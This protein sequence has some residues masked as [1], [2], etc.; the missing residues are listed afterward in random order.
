MDHHTYTTLVSA[1]EVD[2]TVNP[3]TFRSKVILISS[4]AYVVL[5]GMLIAMALLIYFGIQH[6]HSAHRTTTLIRIGLF[7]LVM[8]PAFFVVLRM[9]FMRLPAPQGRALTRDEAPRLFGVLDKMRR[10][11]QGPPIHHVLIDE[12]F[13]A[14]ISQRPRWG[15]FGG[16][17]NYLMLGLPYMLSMSPKEMLAT[18]AHEYGH[19]CGNHGK[20]SAWVYRQR[21]TFGAL[22]EQISDS[23]EDNWVH[24]GMARMLDKFMPYYNAHTFVLSRQDEYDADRTATDLVGARANASGLIRGELLGRWIHQEFWPTLFRQANAAAKPA[25]MPFSAMRTAFKASYP[26]W[27]T[28]ENLALAW[29]AK[30]DLH[31]THP[32]LRDRVEATGE[33]ATLPACIEVCAAE[34]LLGGRTRTLID[35]FD[36]DWWEK[37]KKGWQARYQHVTR[38]TT[39][40]QQLRRMPQSEMK[41]ADLQ[42]YAMLSAEFEPPEAAK[43]VLEHLL[44]Q[45]GGPFPRAELEYGRLLLAEQNDL[46]LTHLA[47][48]VKA[49]RQLGEQAARTG[50]AYLL[51]HQGEQQAQQWWDGV[52]P[53][54]DD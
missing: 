9:F 40:L 30:S 23:S 37:E 6:A 11:L 31:D 20:L 45:P 16:H 13:N 29:S 7:T 12:Q 5:F 49:D 4:A 27:A 1:L 10:Q 51:R 28:K 25:F 47:T 26:Q 2:A 18:V 24:G 46:G 8:V 50:Y 22:Y 43:T 32:A 17:T 15:L 44:R 38:S 35:E 33:D 41:L 54:Q 3:G 21:R 39:R 36:R 53:D 48:V 52:V 42:E 34:A 19:V 14:A